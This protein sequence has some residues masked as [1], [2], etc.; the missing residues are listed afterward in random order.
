M[1]YIDLYDMH[2]IPTGKT[3]LRGSPVPEGM[4]RVVVHI[5]IFNS[6]GEMLIQQRQSTKKHFPDM[7]DIS[8]GGQVS[9]GETSELAAQREIYEELGLD[10]DM[11]DMRPLASMSFNEGYDDV[12]AVISD[13]QLSQLILQKEEVKAADWADKDK[14]F[15]MIKAGTFIQY[16]FEYIAMLFF[17]FYQIGTFEQDDLWNESDS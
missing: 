3:I 11:S 2:R 12:Y 15:A 7:W 1:E 5:C 17:L 10:I 14:I 4:Y 9:S 13:V 8:V 16:N 6:K